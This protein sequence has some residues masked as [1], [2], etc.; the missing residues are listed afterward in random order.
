MYSFYRT[1]RAAVLL[2][3]LALSTSL[4][5]QAS[6][7]LQGELQVITDHANPITS[8]VDVW[9]HSAT[10]LAL[11]SEG[12]TSV[13]EWSRTEKVFMFDDM[14]LAN[15]NLVVGGDWAW[16]PSATADQTT[17]LIGLP[18]AERMDFDSVVEGSWQEFPEA[19]TWSWT[20]IGE[21]F[22]F[23]PF[24]G[25]VTVLNTH[26]SQLAVAE[27]KGWDLDTKGQT[28]A[29]FVE[30]DVAL[31]A[32][33]GLLFRVNAMRGACVGGDAI[34]RTNADSAI[35]DVVVSEGYME[36]SVKGALSSGW[37]YFEVVA[38]PTSVVCGALDTTA[39]G[40][41]GFQGRTAGSGRGGFTVAD[42]A[43]VTPG[44]GG[45]TDTSGGDEC[46]PKAPTIEAP[47]RSPC[48]GEGEY[49]YTETWAF[50]QRSPLRMCVGEGLKR[51]FEWSHSVGANFTAGFKEWV[52]LK[53]TGSVTRSEKFIVTGGHCVRAYYCEAGKT[54]HY[55]KYVWGLF[56]GHYEPVSYTCELNK[57]EAQPTCPY[58]GR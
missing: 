1:Q 19:G 22:E 53:I 45:G 50:C 24:T 14:Y 44:T 41:G 46:E 18:E 43:S 12:R 9:G 3:T 56:G 31:A 17:H 20:G 35:T 42:V 7:Q 29:I 11:D 13:Q 23:D 48:A 10:K 32:E 4:S 38:D 27:G 51:E 8:S 49:R 55:S 26:A 58:G 30:D 47:D 16:Q 15:G 40:G 2:A 52:E 54:S 36:L 33:S 34:V 37:N 21:P 25:W 57:L 6:D 39:I 28:L 5:A